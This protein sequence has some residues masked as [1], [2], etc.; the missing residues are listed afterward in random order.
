MN[1][2]G[3]K[4]DELTPLTEQL[5]ELD[6]TVER[7]WW[8]AQLERGVEIT[9]T[10]REPMFGSSMVLNAAASEINSSNRDDTVGMMMRHIKTEITIGNTK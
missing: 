5:Y 1:S 8:L 7:L 3:S 4:F 2:T 6:T 9:D 10:G